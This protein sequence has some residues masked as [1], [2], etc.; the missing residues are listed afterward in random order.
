MDL[1]QILLFILLIRSQTQNETT[2]AQLGKFQENVLENCRSYAQEKCCGQSDAGRHPP[3]SDALL[4][5]DQCT[6]TRIPRSTD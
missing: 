2:Q 3:L 5:P 4:Q 6:E 1:S